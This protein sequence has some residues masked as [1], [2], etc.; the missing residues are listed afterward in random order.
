MGVA[1]PLEPP[2]LLVRPHLFSNVLRQRRLTRRETPHSAAQARLVVLLGVEVKA[3]A[4]PGHNDSKGLRT[5]LLEYGDDAL[6][7]VLLHGSEQ[8]F[9][10][11]RG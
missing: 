7:G 11:V 1:G 10:A 4:N 3:T 9:R 6:G 8:L 5:F 2:D